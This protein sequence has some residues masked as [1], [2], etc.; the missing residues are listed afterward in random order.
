MRTYRDNTV[1]LEH[2]ENN[3]TPKIKEE[4]IDSVIFLLGNQEEINKAIDEVL[5]KTSFAFDEHRDIPYDNTDSKQLLYAEI[6]QTLLEENYSRERFNELV[7][8]YQEAFVNTEKEEEEEEEQKNAVKHYIIPAKD[9]NGQDNK[10]SIRILG[11]VIIAIIAG[12][13]I[14]KL[15]N[16]S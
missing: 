15:V 12:Y 8:T 11:G 5:N 6:K 4:L 9:N 1:L 13:I 10:S 7:N 2:I 3:D 16:K 14:Y